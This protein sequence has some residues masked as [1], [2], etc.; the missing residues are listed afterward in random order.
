[1]LEQVGDDLPIA[2]CYNRACRTRHSQPDAAQ[3]Y[4]ESP[5]QC[6]L[7]FEANAIVIPRG[8][9]EAEDQL[10][11]GLRRKMAC[12]IHRH[13]EAREARF[14]RTTWDE[15][16][17]RIMLPAAGP[18]ADKEWSGVPGTWTEWWRSTRL[19]ACS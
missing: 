18:G 11:Q 9:E 12:G 5:W 13:L 19:P 1:M 17:R 15:H 10:V 6:D 16:Q 2:P 4:R 14:I 3:L 8:A 7:P